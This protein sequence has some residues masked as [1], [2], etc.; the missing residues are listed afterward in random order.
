[1]ENKC[2]ENC[3]FYYEKR[4][5]ETGEQEAYCSVTHR[6]AEVGSYCRDHQ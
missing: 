3:Y 6:Y 5:Q 1:M 4:C 2:C